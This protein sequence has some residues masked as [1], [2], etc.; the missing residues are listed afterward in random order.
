MD[1]GI[2]GFL[3]R[4]R[5]HYDKVI[6]FAV[7][8]ALIS[9]IALLAVKI[10]ML[11]QDEI[12]FKGWLKGLRPQNPEAVLVEPTAYDQARQYLSTPLLLG[13]PGVE[14]SSN[15]WMFVP[16][17]RYNCRECRHPVSIAA[18]ICPFCNNKP[19]EEAKPEP[20]DHDGDG[21]PTDWER[22]YKL[23]PFDATDA[24]KDFDGDDHTNL[25]E[26]NAGKDP[27]DPNSRPP[28][29]GRVKVD[30]I[31]APQFGLMYKSKVRTASG[32]KYG[33]NYRL[34][35]GEIR[36]EFVKIGDTV[37]GFK[38]EGHVEKSEPAKPPALGKVD[39]SELTLLAPKGD[40]IVLV[41]GRAVSYVEL[42]A[43][44][45]LKLRD[46]VQRFD[47]RKGDSFEVDG[48]TYSVIDVDAKGRSVVIKGTASDSA[49][50][51]E[52][53]PGGGDR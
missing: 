22:Q 8:L 2:N 19:A 38:V 35:S 13:V 33:L 17:T 49:I 34:P 31:T 24:Q 44:L 6:A 7:L 39:V 43:H 47:V 42:I 46:E 29:I 20:L 41:M 45:S 52:Q 9:S 10:N 48:G 16:E 12:D 50:T 4:I 27:T 32:Y 11:R 21:M 23:D 53:E 14:G 15:T 5:E 30:G 37:E 51:I 25:E 1:L 40:P 28:S 26:F 18:E 36:T 3:G